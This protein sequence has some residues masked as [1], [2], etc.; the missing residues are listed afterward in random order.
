MWR[1]VQGEDPKE[2]VATKLQGA[3]LPTF[4]APQV[5]Y[6]LLPRMGVS[7]IAL[8]PLAAK[9]APLLSSIEAEGWKITYSGADG[10]VLDATSG[11]TGPYVVFHAL[12]IR[13]DTD[14]LEAFTSA[15][16]PYRKEVVIDGAEEPIGGVTG[17]AK[18]VSAVQR[19]NSASV[20]VR[21][22]KPGYLVI[23]EM[24][25]PG[26]SATVNGINATV[27]RVNYNQQAV[28]IPSGH[29]VVALSY[30]PKGFETGLVLSCVSAVACL[31]ILLWPI[32]DRR[33]RRPRARSSD[34][35]RP[36]SSTD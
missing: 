15:G 30:R 35:G 8:T 29:S 21:S 16:F 14:A 33:R 17:Q 31:I 19:V 34:K 27:E 1:V 10:S 23:P 3:F 18:I 2:V 26:W 9:E 24:W 25:D 11:S 20:V 12:P 5:R 22:S 7:Q 28:A 36:V 32:A 4:N 6:D 13:S